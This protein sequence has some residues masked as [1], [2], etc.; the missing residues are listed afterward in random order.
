MGILFVVIAVNVFMYYYERDIV[1]TFFRY[2]FFY[3]RFIDDIFVIWD[4]FRDIFLEFL[5]VINIKD[6]RIKII[7]EISEFKILFLDL[8]FFKVDGCVTL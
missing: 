8:F 2:F 4:G 1:E 3:K 7:Y 6:E 5:Y